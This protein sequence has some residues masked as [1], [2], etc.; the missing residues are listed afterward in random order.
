MAGPLLV[1]EHEFLDL[2]GRGLGQ[3]AKLDRPRHL[4]VR[5]VGADVIEISASLDPRAG[6]SVTK[7]FGRS[8]QN[9]SGTPTTA[10]SSTAGWRLRARST[11]MVEMFSPPV[12]MMSFWRSRSSR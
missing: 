7:A 2:A 11:S 3:R 12:M 4:E 5:E 1:P 10:T 9:S 6:A 8:P